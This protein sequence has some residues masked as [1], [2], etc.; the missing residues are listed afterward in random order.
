MG[1]LAHRI[2]YKPEFPRSQQLVS[3]AE[4][5]ITAIRHISL[6]C[7]HPFLREPVH[8]Q[9]ATV[10]LEVSEQFHKD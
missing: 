5:T 8:I 10:F 2:R 3:K 6:N 1:I 4:F 9:S 7:F